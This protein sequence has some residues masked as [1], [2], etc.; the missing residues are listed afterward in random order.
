M[1]AKVESN[2]VLIE[3]IYTY[4]N[5]RI[6]VIRNPEYLGCGFYG[7]DGYCALPDVISLDGEL[8]SKRGWNSDNGHVYY[9]PNPMV[10]RIP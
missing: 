8:F 6:V 4:E 3:Q 10:A 7:Y 2:Y 9:H 5:H 1:K